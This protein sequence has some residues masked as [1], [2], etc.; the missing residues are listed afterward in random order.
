MPMK[1]GFNY[2]WA[3]ERYGMQV[4]P[5]VTPNDAAW[6]AYTDFLSGRP[7]PRFLPSPT[8]TNLARNLK[9]L[10]AMGISVVRWFILGSGPNFGR[11]PQRTLIVEGGRR[12]TVWKFTPPPS[13]DPRFTIHFR[14]MLEV[15]R[16]AKM[17]LIPSIVDFPMFADADVRPDA[18]GLAYGGRADLLRDKKL[19]SYF[20]NG[21]FLDLLL[22]A[23]DFRDVIYAFEVMNEPIWLLMPDVHPELPTWKLAKANE[24]NG[25][26][27][28]YWPI[29]SSSDLTDFLTDALAL[30]KAFDLPSTVGH[31]F[32]YD[33]QNF[34]TG[35]LP[36]FHY[37]AKTVTVG[38]FS[39]GDR[40]SVPTFSG[41]PPPFLGEFSSDKGSADQNKP[42][43]DLS[44]KDTTL[45]RLKLLEAKGCQLCLIWP[46]LGGKN[47]GDCSPL[48]S[49]GPTKCD[50]IKL[51]PD[52]IAQIKKFTGH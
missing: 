30:V 10:S 40:T 39:V 14:A 18:N 8:I 11:S 42:W 32:Y 28:L 33:I 2:A 46:D 7:V 23:R 21:L 9:E 15:F 45:E 52:T 47:I 17:Q 50:P 1:V 19:R 35:S 3:W 20:I 44:G 51:H 24:Q 25:A 36:Q 37:Y 27:L 6:D 48:Y 29:V 43:P 22:V 13:I 49:G 31:R 26:V 38:G 4:G 41:N 5:Y 34:P 12:R 16:A